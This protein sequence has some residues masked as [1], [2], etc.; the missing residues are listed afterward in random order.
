[1]FINLTSSITLVKNITLFFDFEGWWETPYRRHFDLDSSI[2]NILEILSKYNAKA[3]FNTLGVIAENF[4][5]LIKKINGEGHEIASHGY[6]HENFIQLDDVQLN[7]ALNKT[8]I[9]IKKI[10][11]QKPIGIRSPWLYHN[12]NIY[13]IF[14][15]RG[16]KWASNQRFHHYST[17][18]RPDISLT[19]FSPLNAVRKA[20]IKYRV[21]RNINKPFRTGKLVEI[22]LLS[23]MDG[24]LLGMFDPAQHSPAKWMNYASNSL[25]KQYAESND[26]FN[27]N[28][29][30]WII[31]TANRLSLLENILKH[32]K[33]DETNK[34][35]LAKDLIKQF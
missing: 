18:Q 13:R 29:H 2:N 14:Q 23:L 11:G 21:L 25:L 10:I 15:E 20:I 32:I 33:K 30:C 3:V 34:F 9:A 26:Y 4:P 27:L 1:M 35:I 16:Y 17:L 5:N 8:E 28:F 22:P 12:A 19:A 24:E 6:S 7:T 31:G